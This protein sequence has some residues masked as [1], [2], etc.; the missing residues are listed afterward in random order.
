MTN[1][2]LILQQKWVLKK[3]YSKANAKGLIEA[4]IA[5]R[6]L[7]A[8]K[9]KQ[10]LLERDQFIINITLSASTA[11]EILLFNSRDITAVIGQQDKILIIKI[12][13][14]PPLKEPVIKVTPLLED[15]LPIL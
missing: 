2:L 13:P 8:C 3:A 9:R 4:E 10:R 7:N 1:P 6:E 11:A 5:G 15:S 12:T 14:P